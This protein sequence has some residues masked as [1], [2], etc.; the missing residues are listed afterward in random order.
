MVITFRL[1][2]LLEQTATF[3]LYNIISLV[4]NRRA[5]FTARYGLSPYIT[6]IRCVFKV[7]MYIILTIT[8]KTLHYRYRNIRTLIVNYFTASS[9]IKNFYVDSPNIAR[10]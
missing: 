7:F 10:K 5:V 8:S 2:V 4:Y 6:Q 3:A 9:F 1:C